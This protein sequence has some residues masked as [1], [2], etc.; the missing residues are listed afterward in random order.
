MIIDFNNDDDDDENK[1][2]NNNSD[3]DS[4]TTVDA[5]VRWVSVSL[6]SIHAYINSLCRTRLFHATKRLH[7]SQ[8]HRAALQKIWQK[9]LHILLLPHCTQN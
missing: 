5:D 7:F 6:S 2:S 3:D 8:L 4:H 9:Q 1:D